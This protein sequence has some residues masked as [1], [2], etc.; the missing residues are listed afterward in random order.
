MALAQDVE[1]WQ[2]KRPCINPM[3]VRG[4]GPF[5]KLR[6]WYKQFYNPRD[7]AK[8]IQERV[9]GL[10]VSVDNRPESAKAKGVAA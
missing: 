8:K 7:E 6:I 4:D 2:H 3:A 5:G 1:V 9:N 10:V